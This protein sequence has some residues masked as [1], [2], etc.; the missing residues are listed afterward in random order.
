MRI[1]DLRAQ[2]IFGRLKTSASMKEHTVYLRTNIAFNVVI[3]LC[4]KNKNRFKK[5]AFRTVLIEFCSA[6]A[7]FSFADYS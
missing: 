2:A 7:D 1:C 3:Q 6:F 4:P 5:M